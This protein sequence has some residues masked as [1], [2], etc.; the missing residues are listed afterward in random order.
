MTFSVWVTAGWCT[1][2]L[3]SGTAGEAG[4]SMTFSVVASTCASWCRRRAS[5]VA[6]PRGHARPAQVALTALDVP[7]RGVLVPEVAGLL[8]PVGVAVDDGLVPGGLVDD[9]P[10]GDLLDG[11]LGWSMTVSSQAALSTTVTRWETSSTA[12]MAGESMTVS[13]QAALS[14]TVTSG[15]PPRRRAWPAVDDGLVPGGLVDDG[16]V[17]DLLDGGHGRRVDDGLVPGGL[18]DDGLLVGDGGLGGNGGDGGPVD[19]RA[20]P[21][22]V[23]VRGGVDDGPARAG[24]PPA[25][26]LGGALTVDRGELEVGHLVG[27]GAA[28]HEGRVDDLDQVGDGGHRLVVGRRVQRGVGGGATGDGGRC[29]GPSSTG[30]AEAGSGQDQADSGAAHGRDRASGHGF[31]LQG[32]RPR[33]GS[34]RSVGMTCS[35]TIKV[36][37]E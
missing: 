16:P 6:R 17:G 15:R 19:D 5:P 23:G 28:G 31:S 3:T 2:W 20:Q 30:D 24:R 22:V 21:A 8:L 1:T 32:S 14:T 27:G 12:G 34:S 36:K 7:R 13:S 29:P 37:E 10:V 33:R 18:V 11:G 35:L 9:G 25:L 4:V 26:A